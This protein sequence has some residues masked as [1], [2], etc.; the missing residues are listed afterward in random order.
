M[1]PNKRVSFGKSSVGK[2]RTI[3]TITFYLA[4]LPRDGATIDFNSPSYQEMAL[5]GLF[6]YQAEGGWT[7][8]L[9]C[10][11]ENGRFF[12]LTGTGRSN[13]S[14]RSELDNVTCQFM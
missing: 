1:P 12:P 6:R 8:S 13:L 11:C 10:S 14:M 7:E 3:V 9:D 5:Q 2:K 4:L